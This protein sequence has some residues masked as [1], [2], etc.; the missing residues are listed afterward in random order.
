M[1]EWNLVESRKEASVWQEKVNQ[2][3]VFHGCTMYDSE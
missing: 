2:K 3:I 1:G